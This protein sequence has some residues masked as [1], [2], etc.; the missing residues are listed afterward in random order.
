[1]GTQPVEGLLAHLVVAEGRFFGQ[2]SATVGSGKVAS[3]HRE[4]VD[5]GHLGIEAYPA[6]QVLP[7]HL[8]YGPEIG[9]LPS[10]GGAMDRAQ[11]GDPL[12]VVS[13]EEEED[14]L[15]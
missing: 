7:E 15:V 10:E 14:G 4:T 9:R 2:P 11:S 6:E 8:F 13:V 3:G 12:S 5:Q 1:M